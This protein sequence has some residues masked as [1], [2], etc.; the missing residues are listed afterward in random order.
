M[1]AF[2]ILN[3][4]LGFRLFKFT[5][6]TLGFL[7]G[8][9]VVLSFSSLF[10]GP[11]DKEWLNWTIVGSCAVAGLGIGFLFYKLEKAGFFFLGALGGFF[12]SALL[13]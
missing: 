2:G 10:I 1:I 8:F 9:F 11:V 6:F 13:Y 5:L 3:C 12:L 4:F 7:V